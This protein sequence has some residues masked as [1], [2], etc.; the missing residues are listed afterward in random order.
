MKYK[1]YYLAIVI[2]FSFIIASCS[3]SE[4]ATG[5]SA[6][7]TTAVGKKDS[8]Y[9]F[10]QVTPPAP[11]EPEKKE[12]PAQNYDQPNLPVTFYVVQIGAFTTKDKA[13]EFA[14]ESRNKI[15]DGINVS[16]NPVVNLYVVQLNT[17][18]SSHDEAE[19]VRNDLWKLNEFK[20][21]WIVTEQK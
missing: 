7:D 8:L 13:D 1:K 21:A 16:F 14:S 11:K 17:H 12:A 6:S 5:S 15:Q 3:S 19:K 9:V 2:I 4:K 10:D 20:D 18:Y